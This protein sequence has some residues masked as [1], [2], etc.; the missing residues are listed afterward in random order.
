MSLKICQMS[1]ATS[2]QLLRLDFLRVLCSHEHF[3]PLNLPFGTPLTPSGMNSPTS[4]ISS[5][6]SHR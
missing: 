3:F 6:A 4:S 5:A 1:D 2:L